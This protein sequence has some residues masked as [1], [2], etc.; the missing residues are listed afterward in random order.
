MLRQPCS[1]AEEALGCAKQPFVSQDSPGWDGNQWGASPPHLYKH[2]QN[3]FM[4][5]CLTSHLQRGCD[6]QQGGD[7]GDRLRPVTFPYFFS[8]AKAI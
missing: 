2:G 5:F 8:Q 1:D 6:V 4:S 3:L 7:E